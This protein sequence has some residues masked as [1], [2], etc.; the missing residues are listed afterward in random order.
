MQFSSCWWRVS[1]RTN[2]T[3]NTGAR[4]NGTICVSSFVLCVICDYYTYSVTDDRQVRAK[5][6]WPQTRRPHRRRRRRRV[7]L[8]HVIRACLLSDDVNVFANDNETIYTI[9]TRVRI[10]LHRR[11]TFLYP[12]TII[13]GRCTLQHTPR[14]Y[15][16][17]RTTWGNTHTHTRAY[18]YYNSSVHKNSG[19]TKKFGIFQIT[20]K[21]HR[22][23][24]YIFMCENDIFVISKNLLEVAVVYLFT[25]I[26]IVCN[27]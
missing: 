4:R 3:N 27:L 6:L 12:F 20:M 21:M 26:T 11:N 5:E 24:Y 2:C 17:N 18:I 15:K 16:P 7:F 1:I 13:S 14:Y 25:L 8:Q 22:K 19:P 10:V 23:I 9:S